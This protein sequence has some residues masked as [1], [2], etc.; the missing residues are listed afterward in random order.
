[1]YRKKKEGRNAGYKWIHKGFT[2]VTD[3]IISVML[4]IDYN[5]LCYDFKS[6][7]IAKQSINI[8]NHGQYSINHKY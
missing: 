2:H 4:L 6:L 1:M 3:N 7:K 5:K 8:R